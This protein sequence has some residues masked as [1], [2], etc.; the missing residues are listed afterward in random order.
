MLFLPCISK[1]ID[2]HLDNQPVSVLQSGLA[3][4]AAVD[5][6]KFLLTA[7]PSGRKTG[8]YG[9][10]TLRGRSVEWPVCHRYGTGDIHMVQEFKPNRSEEVEH[11]QGPKEGAKQCTQHAQRHIQTTF[12]QNDGAPFSRIPQDENASNKGYERRTYTRE[13]E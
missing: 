7:M 6:S 5:G 2:R 10:L 3:S 12:I 8:P 11:A 9:R 1:S 4:V 13:M